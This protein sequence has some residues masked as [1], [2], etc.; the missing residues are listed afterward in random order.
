MLL[1]SIASCLPS[2]AT[3]NNLFSVAKTGSLVPDISLEN[4][5]HSFLSVD[6]S[7]AINKQYADIQQQLSAEQLSVFNQDLMSTLGGSTKVAFG[8]VGVVALA[9][10]LLLDALV[11]KTTRQ[12]EKNVMN[13]T[14][15]ILGISNSSRIGSLIFEYMKLVPEMANKMDTMAEMTELYGQYL[16]YELID[17]FERM[18]NKK[19]MGTVAMKEWLSGAAFHLHMRIHEIRMDSIPRGSAEALRMSYK[20]AFTS[21]IKLYTAYLRKH[22]Q[23]TPPGTGTN[24]TS[25]L[26]VIE[27]QRNVTHS[28]QHSPCESKVIGDALLTR[29]IAS[30]DIE[31]SKDFFLQSECN[32]YKLINQRDDFELLKI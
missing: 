5:L 8:G 2:L 18:T 25:G 32:F 3:I 26:L 13:T 19:R 21:L 31:K 11:R 10:S 29:I 27:P 20:T 7:A 23:E 9:L 30:Q 12:G 6:S 15:M 24:N 1:G 4:T 17:H 22:I 16:N 14:N 28:V